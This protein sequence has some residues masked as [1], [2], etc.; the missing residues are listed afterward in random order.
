MWQRRLPATAY[1]MSY[2]Q[3]LQTIE[4]DEPSAHLSGSIP[5]GPQK[6]SRTPVVLTP[7]NNATAAATSTTSASDLE[8]GT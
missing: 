4:P 6:S 1:A 2:S 5:S 3:P 7:T 8:S